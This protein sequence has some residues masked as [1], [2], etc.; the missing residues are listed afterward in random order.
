LNDR[1]EKTVIID[2]ERFDLVKRMWKLM[3]TGNYTPPKVAEIANEEWG[4]R[5]RRSKKR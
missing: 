4:F 1:L 2:P 3:L 5:T